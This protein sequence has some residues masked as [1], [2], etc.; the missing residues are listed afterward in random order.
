MP[1]DDFIRD[2]L[3]LVYQSPVGAASV[4]SFPIPPEEPTGAHHLALVFIVLSTGSL[5]SMAPPLS[6]EA[7]VFY[8]IL[9]RAAL[10]LEP[11]DNGCSI[12]LVQTLN[13]MT[14]QYVMTTCL[15]SLP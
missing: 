5:V 15:C 6:R 2:I 3:E 7:K 11:L 14:Y 10:A 4:D 1:K 8:R 13:M 9:A 12:A